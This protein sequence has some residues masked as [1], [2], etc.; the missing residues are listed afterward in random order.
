VA[1]VGSIAIDH[2]GVG[3]TLVVVEAKVVADS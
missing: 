1:V 3:D 2:R